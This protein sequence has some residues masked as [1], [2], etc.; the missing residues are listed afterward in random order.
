VSP[1]TRGLAA[2]V[3][4]VLAP[5]AALVAVVALDRLLAARPWP[6]PVQGALDEPAHLL[7]AGL[8]LAA[9]GLL[10]RPWAR[11]ALAGAVLVDLDHLLLWFGAPVAVG[12]G[13]PVSHSLAAVALLLAVAAAWPRQRARVAG[14]A[15]GIGLHVVRDLASGP[16]VPLLWPLLP[17]NLRVSPATYLTVLAVAAAVAAL[18]A[19]GTALRPPPRPEDPRSPPPSI[20]WTDVPQR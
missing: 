12:D 5:A 17:E 4:R 2:G 18:R 3:V 20:G 19:L 9:A 15:V 8:L 16:G 7:T 1:A 14:L 6:L 10:G 13:R 11:W